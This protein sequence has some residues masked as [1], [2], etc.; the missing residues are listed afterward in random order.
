LEVAVASE[1]FVH[2][3]KDL[4]KELDQRIEKLDGFRDVLL[5]K[6]GDNVAVKKNTK[7]LTR[8]IVCLA[9]AKVARKAMEDSCCD[10]GCVFEPHDR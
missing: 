1:R 7:E 6:I 8:V 2:T 5:K 4:C 10:Y 3:M 9:H